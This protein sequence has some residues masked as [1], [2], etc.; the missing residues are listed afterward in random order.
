MF[1]RRPAHRRP[2]LD[3]FSLCRRSSWRRTASPK[4]RGV[5]SSGRA[6]RRGDRSMARTTTPVL[7]RRAGV[8]MPAPRPLRPRWSARL[9]RGRGPCRPTWRR[10]SS[11]WPEDP[12]YRATVSWM[13]HDGTAPAEARGAP[14][15][16]APGRA[17]RKRFLGTRVE[18]RQRTR[19]LSARWAPR[20]KPPARE[21]ARCARRPLPRDRSTRR[22]PGCRSPA[23][24]RRSPCRASC[25]WAHARLAVVALSSTSG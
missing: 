21:F 24:R 1:T 4:S 3:L 19:R 10:R 5:C 6:G 2:R 7:G 11:C 15:Q 9:E 23:P 20:R 14:G 17:R 16:K 22:H 12:R 18:R 13:R 25:G 8:I